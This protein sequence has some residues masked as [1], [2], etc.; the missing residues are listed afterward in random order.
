MVTLTKLELSQVIGAATCPGRAIIALQAFSGIN[1]H[2]L[3]SADGTD[4]LL[5]SD[6]LD[7]A[8]TSTGLHVNEYPVIF[9]IRESLNRRRTQSY[10][11]IF[12]EGLIYINEYL[13]QRMREGEVLSYT[14]PVIRSRDRSP[15]RHSRNQFL[16]SSH[17]ENEVQRVFRCES[18]PWR[19]SILRDYF[20]RNLVLARQDNVITDRELNSLL[21]RSTVTTKSSILSDS[22]S[23]NGRRWLRRAYNA[24]KPFLSTVTNSN[25]GRSLFNESNG[26]VYL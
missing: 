15:M 19:P 25:T 3:G 20:E 26:W 13:G 18:I 2:V 23:P 6:F 8:I 10:A 11:C 7:S 22:F 12:A 5:L 14:S 4:G 24:C 9:K 16:P 1:S 21:N 17:I